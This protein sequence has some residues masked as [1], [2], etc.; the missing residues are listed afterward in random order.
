M[1][2]FFRGAAEQF[3]SLKNKYLEHLP[4]GTEIVITGKSVAIIAKVPEIGDPHHTTFENYTVEAN[5]AL[6]AIAN[7]ILAVQQ[8]N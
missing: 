5:A 6:R 1:K 2:L 4:E 7:I 3:D 8:S